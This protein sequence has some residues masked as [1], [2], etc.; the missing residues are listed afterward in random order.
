MKRIFLKTS[1]FAI[2]F[3]LFTELPVQAQKR[4]L[5]PDSLTVGGN[6]VTT[7]LKNYIVANKLTSS[8]ITADAILTAAILDSNITM[9]KLSATVHAAMGGF[10]TG[11]YGPD[12]V[13]LEFALPD[14][15]LRIKASSVT[16]SHLA[17]ALK[18]SIFQK[19][20]FDVRDYGA[21][22]DDN[23][24]DVAAGQAAADAI[25]IAGGGVLFY[26]PGQYEFYGDSVRI[27]SNTTV[28][29]YNAVFNDTTGGDQFFIV[30]GDSDVTFLG[31]EWDGNADTDGGYTE[32]DMGISLY[33]VFRV[34][35]KDTYMHDLAGDGV[36]ISDGDDV[37]ITNNTFD[38]PHLQDSPWIGRNGVAVVEG[39]RVDISNNSFNKGDPAAIDIEPNS[40][41]LVEIL[42]ITNNIIR[43]SDGHGISLNNSGGNGSIIRDVVIDGNIIV[44]VDEQAIRADSAARVSVT[45]NII[46]GAGEVGI[47]IMELSV[48]ILVMGNTIYG[49]VEN[50][51][52]THTS[53]H[54]VFILGNKIHFNGYHG[55]LI[56]GTSGSE[57]IDVVVIGNYI[58]NNSQDTD[59]T[60]DGILVNYTDRLLVANNYV[61]TLSLIA[62][63]HRNG[64]RVANCDSVIYMGNL[65][66]DAA[67]ADHS[68]AGTTFREYSH[69]AS[70][71]GATENNSHSNFRAPASAD[72]R[73][74]LNTGY[75]FRLD[76]AGG[77]QQFAVS[78]TGE[79]TLTSIVKGTGTFTT[80]AEAD[81]VLIS[82]AASTDEYLL[83]P[84]GT[85]A[86]P[87]DVL[88]WE[89][90]TD[91]LIVHRPASG[92]SGLVYT[93][94]R[95]N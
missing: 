95:I 28:F 84:K 61:T 19:N 21:I 5:R 45:D 39:S 82:G 48:D 20:F 24:S 91:T 30:N 27:W 55:I 15:I 51:I 34:K 32:A 2:L 25:K 22:P 31:G 35:V 16:V 23:N 52:E 67:T 26:F 54:T 87:Q 6:P 4:P 33:D 69:N 59:D 72:F 74:R 83:S 36:Y 13:T 12:D 85:A 65:C 78:A 77:S 14:S 86:D 62:K 58:M 10:G 92:T 17:T 11:T 50:G 56:G 44:D 81:T 75:S 49:C 41:L 9:P 88:F 46:K 94:L 79:L 40:G 53:S 38:I 89:A 66:F 70:G 64:I 60:Y 18:D 1:I 63:H 43:D 80:T 37:T 3:L 29:A 47:E 73:L 42:T 7:F 76:N 8:G 93:W 68:N 57:N 71:A 90:K